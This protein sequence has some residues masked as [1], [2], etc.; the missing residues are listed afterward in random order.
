VVAD[1]HGELH[2]SDLAPS[3][4]YTLLF[5]YPAGGPWQAVATFT[6]GEA[7]T[8]AA[9]LTFVVPAPAAYEFTLTDGKGKPIHGAEVRTLHVGGA[10]RPQDM[11]LPRAFQPREETPGR[12]RV[13]LPAGNI[14]AIATSQGFA[15]AV[16]PMPVD[17]DN[18]VM[19]PGTD[20]TVRAVDRDGAPVAGARILVE[21]HDDP[22]LQYPGAQWHLLADA[23]AELGTTDAHG[24][25]HAADLWPLPISF[26]AKHPR[27]TRSIGPT[28]TPG[29]G[30]PITI[31]MRAAA[32][33]HGTVTMDLHAVGAGF[34]VL[35]APDW[36]TGHPLADNPFLRSQIALTAAD[37][38]FAFR[39]LP[40]GAWRVRALPPK[41]GPDDD[42]LAHPQ[43]FLTQRILLDEAQLYHVDL[44]ATRGNAA[45]PR[46]VGHVCMAGVGVAHALVRVRRNIALADQ[47]S[48]DHG[49]TEARHSLL[50]R[51]YPERLVA[52][53]WQQR[54]LADLQGA[55]AFEDLA[56]GDYQLRVD[57]PV[58]GRWQFLQQT[59]ITIDLGKAPAWEY[60]IDL[61]V[62][63]AQLWF[64]D[65]GNS[66]LPGRIVELRQFTATGDTAADFLL[67][68]DA[69]GAI[70]MDHLPTG[71]WIAT[72]H[73]LDLQFVESDFKVTSGSATLR[74]IGSTR[75]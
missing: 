6:G 15:P 42:T 10:L 8:P 53:P 57:I 44:E 38:T 64:V 5:Q 61:P 60:D 67:L 29:P 51:L 2:L 14:V 40:A 70:E 41:T 7:P 26:A 68:T 22:R 33:V 24:E 46:L 55:Y 13:L 17:G 56:S 21:V 3:C 54:T 11:L 72:P 31:V 9:R 49:N 27:F 59:N 43:Q 23:R 28:L 35:L 32:E 66:P 34:R 71:T 63:S 45:R 58:Q 75:Y 48:F 39:D 73:H 12:Y 47:T 30:K 36:P 25:L 69:R 20:V 16:A 19:L 62:G 74:T 4:R 18:I 65:P 1:F 52:D 50:A 37:G